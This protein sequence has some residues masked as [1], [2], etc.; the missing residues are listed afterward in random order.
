MPRQLRIPSPTGIYHVM[1][2]GINR[3]TIFF[4]E[5]DFMKMEKILR[6]L[7]KPVDRNGKALPPLCN[8]YAYCLMTNHLHLLIAELNES[9]SQVMKRLGVAYVGYFNKRRNRTGP[10]FEGRFRSEPVDDINY[11]ITLLNYIHYNPVKA[12]MTE[13]PGWYKWSSWHEYEL[14]GST[15]EHGICDQNIPFKNLTREQVK[16]VVLKSQ[17]PKDFISKVDRE[18]I[19]NTK[20][21]AILKSLIPDERSGTELKDL[22]KVIKLSIASQATEY[23]LTNGQ[24]SYFLELSQSSIYRAKIKLTNINKS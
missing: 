7:S 17:P 22:P 1:L 14:S 10:L 12:G 19:D 8:I 2:R 9:I 6:S 4:D 21:E 13:K 11:F 16:D 23:G 18:R 3:D 15:Y 5:I 24:L 20:A